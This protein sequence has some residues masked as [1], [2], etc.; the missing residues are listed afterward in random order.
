MKAGTGQ[1]GQDN[2]GKNVAGEEGKDSRVRTA[3]P[4]RHEN[5]VKTSWTGQIWQ[6]SQNRANKADKPDGSTKASQP[7]QD[8]EDRPDGWN[9]T[10]IVM[11]LKLLYCLWNF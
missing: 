1:L 2:R 5:Q 7:R 11:K 8:R 3:W 9:K 6:G 10:K 4:L